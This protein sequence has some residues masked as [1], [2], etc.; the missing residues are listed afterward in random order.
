MSLRGLRTKSYGYLHLSARRFV[1]GSVDDGKAAAVGAE[2]IL[3]AVR[4]VD[5]RCLPAR[6]LIYAFAFIRQLFAG[7]KLALQGH[8]IVSGTTIEALGTACAYIRIVSIVCGAIG[9]NVWID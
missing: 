7:A 9:R 3:A 1:T 4:G 8:A 5:A 6:T 2:A